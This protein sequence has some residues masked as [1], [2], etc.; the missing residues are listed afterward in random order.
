[1]LSY[2]AMTIRCPACETEME[3]T[4]S[5][6]PV[7]MRGRTRHEMMQGLQAPKKLAKSRRRLVLGLL[8]V[9]AAGAGFWQ[10][11]V[12]LG[13]R[14]AAAPLAAPEPAAATPVDASTATASESGG[15]SADPEAAPPTTEPAPPP[16]EAFL[17]ELR[18]Q[19]AQTPPAAGRAPQAPSGDAEIA[20]Q[21]APGAATEPIEGDWKVSGKVYEL[22][23]LKPVARARVVFASRLSGKDHPVRTDAKGAYSVSI[24]KLGESGYDVGFSHP[25]YRDDWIEEA[26][27]TPYH[28]QGLARREEAAFQLGSSAILHVP[29]LPD[30]KQ[31]ALELNL[32]VFPKQ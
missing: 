31:D 17:A 5:S 7:C 14:K 10:L 8:S 21:P 16:N 18:Q 24:P 9:A 20:P 15:P 32:I 27:H 19:L 30:P 6:C 13:A 11:R 4:E 29:Y 1:M 28:K 22:I 23:T 26:E 2:P 25:L 12:E 3:A